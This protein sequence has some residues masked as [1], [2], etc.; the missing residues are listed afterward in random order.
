MAHLTHPAPVSR[1]DYMGK[2][3]DAADDNAFYQMISTSNLES[4]SAVSI[5]E[6]QEQRLAD[7]MADL[8][9][10]VDFKPKLAKFAATAIDADLERSIQNQCKFWNALAA[11][12]HQYFV[13]VFL[14]GVIVLAC[15][16]PAAEGVGCST[17]S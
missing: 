2:L 16:A 17:N 11:P 4:I 1:L 3:H 12:P 15:W 14:G 7:K 6:E 8:V 5:V 13:W 9:N 10:G